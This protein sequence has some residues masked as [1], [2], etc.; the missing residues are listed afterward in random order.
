MIAGIK[1]LL[2]M[3]VVYPSNAGFEATLRVRSHAFATRV[4]WWVPI[5]GAL[6][7]FV[8]GIYLSIVGIREVHS[9]TTGKA[10]LVFLIPV[11]IVLL[12]LAVMAA[13]PGAFIRTV[14]RQH[15]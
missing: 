15:V 6:A 9:T 4:L 8:Y 3:P 2:V 1:H 11:A 5:L 7:G 13:I 12:S 10:A 14:L